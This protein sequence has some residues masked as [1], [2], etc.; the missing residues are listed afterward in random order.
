[1][2]NYAFISRHKPTA[3]QT[4][5]AADAG[6]QLVAVGDMD[7]FTIT[8]EAVAALGDFSGVV[9]V[10]PAAALTLIGAYNV[11]IFE[12]GNRAPEGA[13]PEFYAKSVKI[14]QKTLDP[15]DLQV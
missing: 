7:A 9:V 3:D 1:M 6:I 5:L 11:A 4:S 2:E 12:N 13:K 10:H 8:P 14:F 15:A